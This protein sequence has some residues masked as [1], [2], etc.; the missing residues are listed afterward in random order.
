MP[1]LVISGGMVLASEFE[2]K[3]EGW[4]P[5]DGIGVFMRRGRET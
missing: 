2:M 4:D 5:H 1:R 3:S